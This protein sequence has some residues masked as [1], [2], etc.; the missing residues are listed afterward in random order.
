MS[1]AINA[2]ASSSSSSLDSGCTEC[3][4]CAAPGA[5]LWESEMRGPLTTLAAHGLIIPISLDYLWM[6]TQHDQK[7]RSLF[8][9]IVFSRRQLPRCNRKECRWVLRN[10]FEY[11]GPLACRKAS[12]GYLIESSFAC[13]P[14]KRATFQAK[15]LLLQGE[16][17]DRKEVCPCAPGWGRA[18]GTHTHHFAPFGSRCDPWW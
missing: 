17:R 14:S 5:A 18:C 1:P 12:N 2:V 13:H 16:L 6:D 10:G 8:M 3:A 11:N 7:L 9:S 15:C 4:V